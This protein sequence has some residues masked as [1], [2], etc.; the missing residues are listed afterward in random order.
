MARKPGREFLLPIRDAGGRG[1]SRGCPAQ[2]SR[3]CQ[4]SAPHHPPRE[5][6]GSAGCRS[7]A[8]RDR[9]AHAFKVLVADDAPEVV[10]DD[11]LGQELPRRAEQLVVQ[12]LAAIFA[13]DLMQDRLGETIALLEDIAGDI[14][15]RIVGRERELPAR[16]IEKAD[17]V[18]GQQDMYHTSAQG[19]AGT[20]QTGLSFPTGL[21][22]DASGNLFVADTNNNRILRYPKPF[23][24]FQQSGSVTPDLW[25]DPEE[26]RVFLPPS[27][28]GAPTRTARGPRALPGP[29]RRSRPR[30]A[31]PASRAPG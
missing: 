7:A 4:R 31:S 21:M 9:P 22:V 14:R 23:A 25:A 12:E 30:P 6:A 2:R 28:E 18:I 27:S 8:G 3:P 13:R 10:L 19:P 15:F 17:L 29:G 11:V 24:Q 16:V 1:G 26:M 5:G 20:F